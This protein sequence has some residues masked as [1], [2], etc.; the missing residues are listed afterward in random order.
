VNLSCWP[1][2]Q[3]TRARLWTE[4][5]YQMT[6]LFRSTQALSDQV[7]SSLRHPLKRRETSFQARTRVVSWAAY[8]IVVATSAP[9]LSSIG[10]L[11]DFSF[12]VCPNFREKGTP[13]SVVNQ[14]HLEPTHSRRNALLEKPFSTSVARGF[15]WLVATA[16][17]ICTRGGFTRAHARALSRHLH[18]LLLFNLFSLG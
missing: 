11:T 13:T 4:R 12:A 18:V 16:T 5:W 6:P 7:I 9:R 14:R 1:T 8:E 15:T 2:F 10:M 17:K 3:G